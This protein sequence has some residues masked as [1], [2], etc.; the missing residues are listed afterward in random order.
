MMVM[1]VMIDNDDADGDADVIKGARALAS[2]H[3]S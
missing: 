2:E 1:V 3:L